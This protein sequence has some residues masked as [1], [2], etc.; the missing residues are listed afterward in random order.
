MGTVFFGCSSDLWRRTSEIATISAVP[1][2]DVIF[3]PLIIELDTL[4]SDEVLSY[5]FTFQV[6]RMFL[7]HHLKLVREEFRY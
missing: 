5:D 2:N 1:W 4:T 6:D 3:D 7:H